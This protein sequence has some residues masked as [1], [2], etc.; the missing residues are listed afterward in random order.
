MPELIYLRSN[1]DFAHQRFLAI[2]CILR[3]FDAR[4]TNS[5]ISEVVTRLVAQWQRL[6]SKTSIADH[7]DLN[8]FCIRESSHLHSNID[9]TNQHH[10]LEY[11]MSDSSK[12][13]KCRPVVHDEDM[14]H[15]S[16]QS[17]WSIDA[18]THSSTPPQPGL[19]HFC[20]CIWKHVAPGPFV[21][22]F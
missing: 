10:R 11:M 14:Q 8:S 18:A 2:R 22:S 6:Q 4:N 15:D 1:N 21:V 20:R 12:Q 3:A 5:R 7:R 19:E 9:T 17:P 16:S 13:R